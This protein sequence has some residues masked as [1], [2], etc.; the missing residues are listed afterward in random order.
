MS[1][2]TGDITPGLPITVPDIARAREWFEQVLGCVTPLRFG[3]FSDPEGDFMTQLLDVHARA[4]IHEINM[5]RCGANGANVELFEWS[6]PD[7]DRTSPLN[8]DFAGSHIALYVED[9]GAAAAAMKLG[10]GVRPFLGPFPVTG[11]PAAGQSINYFF[12]P[13]LGHHVELISY[14][15]GMAY[16]E[17]AETPLWSPRDP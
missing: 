15:N 7:Q 8:S 4:V 1:L 6:S 14:P 3:P 17:T 9:I 16:E 12:S 5:L 13:Q 2:S 10:K 11:G